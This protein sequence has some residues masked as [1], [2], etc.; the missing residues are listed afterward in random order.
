M[1][2][3]TDN[4][5]EV[6]EGV[7]ISAARIALLDL[8]DIAQLQ[9]LQ[10]SFA[11]ATRVASII[12]LPDGTPITRPSNFC[13]LCAEIIRGT[14]QGLAACMHSDA[15]VGAPSHDGPTVR[16]CLSGGLWDAGAS[17]VVA[18]EHVGNWLI[19]QVR[20][21]DVQANVRTRAFAAQIGADPAA[22]DAAL[23]E[24]PQMSAEQF[25]AIADYLYLV[26]GELSRTAY[27]NHQ[28]AL[29]IAERARSSQALE[30]SE[31]RYREQYE[32]SPVGY[33]SLDADGNFILVNAAW[34]NALGYSEA[35]VV[36]SW[37]G[38]FLAPDYRDAFRERFPLFK[39]AGE[40]HSEFEMVCKDGSRRFIGFDGII[41]RDE[42]GNFKQTHCVLQDI[43]E[44]R[45]A[46]QALEESEARYRATFEQAAVGVAQVGVDGRFQRVN[47]RLCEILGYSHEELT[48]LC[49][50]D[51]THP[52]SLPDNTTGAGRLLSGERDEYRAEK[53]YVRKDGSTVWASL[54]SSLVHDSAG[55]P[56]Y[57]VSVIEDITERKNAETA[58]SGMNIRLEKMVT[59]IT[60]A[61]GKV[62]ESRDPYTQGHQ[63]GVARIA[64]AIATDLGMS[65]DEVLGIEIASLVHDIGKLAIPVE[66]LSKPGRLSPV[67][68]QI[69]KEHPQHG[70]EI[71][72][73]IDFPWPVAE[74]ALQH[75]ERIDGSGYPK[76]LSGD[77]ISLPARI[78][79]VADVVD[80]MASHRPYRPALG[81]DVA[82]NEVGS[83]PESYGADVVESCLRLYEAGWWSEPPA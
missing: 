81:I 14:D 2:S 49:F 47:E 75:H 5:T 63:E 12:T 20:T 39:A 41:G 55:M 11:A 33:Q 29:L 70:Y 8:F 72:R 35:E 23:A 40:I 7:E 17:I 19:G 45:R 57:F 73:D 65:D 76:G 66:I 9:A 48:Q 31:R 61:M 78:V 21:D 54:T 44:T 68:F 51:V 16:T 62:T 34:L 83:H 6:V 71:L 82:I 15:V 38:D 18:G 36:G 24:V 42:E 3:G 64:V 1:D 43:T 53:L 80:A 30:L 59:D 58:V 77:E 28:Q 27:L 37:F 25:R 56:K 52:S 4:A 74:I 13:R 60:Q 67:E 26:V 32:R 22:F 79:A 10:D 69:I 50:P 46:K